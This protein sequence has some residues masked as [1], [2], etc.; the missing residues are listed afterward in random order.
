MRVAGIKE[1]YKE[2]DA[3]NAWEQLPQLQGV[4]VFW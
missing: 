4:Q 2:G 3:S 1:E